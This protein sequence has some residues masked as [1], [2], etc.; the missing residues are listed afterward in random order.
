MGVVQIWLTALLGILL[1][2]LVTLVCRSRELPRPPFRLVLIALFCWAVF[3]LLPIATLSA[4]YRL[5]LGVADDLLLSLAGIRVLVWLLLELPG[6]LGWWPSPPQLLVQLLCLG[7]WGLVSV[8]VVRQSTRFDLVNLVATSAVLTAVIGLA[9][10]EVLK[11]LFSGLELQLGQDF[12]IGDWLELPDGR[13]GTVVAISWR[14][15][16]LR[17]MED[18]LLVVPNSKITADI[19]LNRSSFGRCSDRFTV[20][21]DYDYP[22]ARALALLAQVVEQHPLVLSDPAPQVRLSGFLASS[23]SYEIQIWQKAVGD[24]ALLS[25]RSQLQQQIWY[26]LRRQGQSFPFPVQE[27]RPR[28]SALPEDQ[29]HLAKGEDCRRAITSLPMFADLSEAELQLLVADST[30]L[31]FGP[32]EAVVREGEEGESL[33]CLL[34][35]RVDVCKRIEADRLVTVRQLQGGDVFGE[36]TLFLDAP[37]SATVRTVEECLLLRVGRPAVRRLLADNPALFERIATLVSRRQAE[38]AQLSNDQG[39]S[40]TN[41]LIAT[42]KRLFLVVSGG[43]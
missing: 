25:L 28:R 17:T 16:R 24:R 22:P 8:L 5:G 42:M 39:D 9:A 7:S 31:T 29:R 27:I 15:T 20:D 14:E 3:A 13:R 21:L 35:G 36:M 19:F 40:F 1:M 18:C 26:A 30:I 32:G 2:G 43:G 12:A 11:D 37:R 23:I 41:G 10:Q 38:L 4:P 6:G 34:R 33:F